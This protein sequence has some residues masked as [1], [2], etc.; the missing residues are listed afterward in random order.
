VDG[1]RVAIWGGVECSVVR[2]GDRFVDELKK[3]GHHDR[4]GDLDLL[5]DLGIRTVRYPVLWERVA[6]EGSKRADWSWT[7][8][9][10]ERLRELGIWPI[11]TLVHHGSGPRET[12]LLDDDFPRRLATFAS[13]VARRYPWLRDFTP[14]NEPLTTARFSALYGI[15]YPHH[16]SDAS[17][18]RALLNQLRAIAASM[19]AIREVI[20]DARLIL[21]EDLGKTHATAP[22]SYQARFENARRWLS[23]DLLC[24]ALDGNPD[25]QAYLSRFGVEKSDAAF[26]ECACRPD[27]IGLNYYVTSERY[28]DH[29]L[30]RYPCTTWG[31]NG[32]HRY[33]DVE[34][35]R[36]PRGADGIAALLREAADRYAG[37]ALALTECH[38]GCTPDEQLRWLDSAYRAACAVRAQGAD[39]Q[40]MTVWSLFGSSDWD[41]L[42]TRDAGHYESG[43]Y[44]VAAGIPR[45][46]MLTRWVRARAK[47]ELFH[48]PV[49]DAPGWWQSPA[50][51]LETQ[52]LSS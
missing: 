3:T 34:A 30:G 37:Y 39:V 8:Q 28:L 21:A 10:L 35:V 44:D 38:L 9:R 45:E 42:L 31:G 50:R 14:V 43:C 23:I 5:A 27:V 13:A 12:N 25:M 18:L 4:L 2:I 47:G 19:R 20:P 51:L 36:V 6:P 15:W 7:D 17:F 29:R 32:R 24:G 46:T 26:K 40:A 48:D 11:V 16:R 1:G 49:L 41:S 22:L 52:A 33:A